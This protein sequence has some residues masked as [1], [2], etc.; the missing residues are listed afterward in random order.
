MAGRQLFDDL[1]CSSCHRGASPRGPALENLWG[2]E[3]A[4]QNGQK[5]LADDDY[6]RESIMRPATKIVAGYQPLMPSFEGQL[7]EEDLL[8]L[9][10]YIKSMVAESRTAP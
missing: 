8:E 6:L 3:V 2:R 9:L 10:A 4:L 1:R 7:D 5:V